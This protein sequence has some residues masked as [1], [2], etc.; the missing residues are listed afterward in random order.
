MGRITKKSHGPAFSN[1]S[2]SQVNENPSW[3][4]SAEDMVRKGVYQ[5]SIQTKNI[6]SNELASRLDKN[7]IEYS[8]LDRREVLVTSL[9]KIPQPTVICQ[10]LAA[11]FAGF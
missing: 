9:Y 5:W 11:S 3:C 4:A 6:P 1:V 2:S 10:D 8:V 7:D